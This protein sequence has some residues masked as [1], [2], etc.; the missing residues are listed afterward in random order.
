MQ[1][2]LNRPKIGFECQDSSLLDPGIFL[3]VLLEAFLEVLWQGKTICDLLKIS[4]L[5]PKVWRYDVGLDPLNWQ[6][7]VFIGCLLIL[8]LV[9]ILFDHLV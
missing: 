9:G 3:L 6:Q 2:Q 5:L 4:L 7:V 8:V 1:G